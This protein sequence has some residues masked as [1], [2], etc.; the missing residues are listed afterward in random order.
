MSYT[1]TQEEF[2]RLK[3]RLTFR[4]NRLNRAKA[5]LVDKSC[6][7]ESQAKVVFEADQL[8]KE[9]DYAINIFEDRGFPDA[10][11]NW[12]RAKDDAQLLIR[13]NTHE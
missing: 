11:N 6:N 3:R 7:R 12:S 5:A 8:V 9:V 13:I 10:H 1:L 2:V 4:Q